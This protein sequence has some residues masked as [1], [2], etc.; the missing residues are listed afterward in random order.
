MQRP[1]EEKL[2]QMPQETLLPN[3]LPTPDL[4]T[5]LEVQATSYFALSVSIFNFSNKS[6]FSPPLSEILTQTNVLVKKNLCRNM[7]R[8]NLKISLKKGWFLGLKNPRFG[9]FWGG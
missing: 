9:G 8:K 6:N 4:S 2:W 1:S 7:M 3:P 5:P